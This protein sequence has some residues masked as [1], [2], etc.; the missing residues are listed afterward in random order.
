MKTILIILIATITI[1]AQIPDTIPTF[2]HLPKHKKEFYYNNYPMALY[3][4]YKWKVPVYH[5]LSIAAQKTNY[6]RN[7]RYKVGDV[8]GTG[9]KYPVANAWDEFGLMM[10]TTMNYVEMT[11]A[12][13]ISISKKTEELGLKF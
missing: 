2:N 4:L 11:R 13:A 3:T 8:F 10:K 1:Q 7:G 12:E 9:K 5:T 6:G